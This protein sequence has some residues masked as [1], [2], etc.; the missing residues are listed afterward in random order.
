MKICL[1]IIGIVFFQSCKF[2]DKD[3]DTLFSFNDPLFLGI[4]DIAIACQGEAVLTQD[5]WQNYLN[6]IISE[7]KINDSKFNF[8]NIVTNK[9]NKLC[10]L[11]NFLQKKPGNFDQFSEAKRLSHWINIYHLLIIHLIVDRYTEVN[12]KNKPN[13]IEFRSPLNIGSKGLKIF[14]EYKWLIFGKYYS[15]DQIEDEIKKFNN[16]L[17]SISLFRGMGG[18]GPIPSIAFDESNLVTNIEE[19]FTNLIT[20]NSFFDHETNPK[21]VFIPGAI[22]L[23]LPEINQN[24]IGLRNLM[25]KYIDYSVLD[26]VIAMDEIIN[27]NLWIIQYDPVNWQLAE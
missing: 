5:Q 20:N 21:I 19:N 27:Q 2:L 11:V 13:T 14:S 18:F 12:E 3:S 9:K 4:N 6:Q 17:V 16:P 1:I 7:N 15:L 23:F 10:G 22:E 26:E 24:E 8:N 25:N